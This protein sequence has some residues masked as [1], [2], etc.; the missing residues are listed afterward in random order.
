MEMASF[1]GSIIANQGFMFWSATG[2]VALG[3]TLVLTSGFIHFRRLR[4][5]PGRHD[6]HATVTLPEPIIIPSEIPLKQEMNAESQK[7]VLEPGSRSIELNTQQLRH[8][9]ARLR[10]AADQLEDFRHSSRPVPAESAES[11]LKESAEG[12]DYLFRTGIG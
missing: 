4:S 5:R 1:S 10:T 6:L 12:V 8:L 7:D 9:L 2:A 11:S 3:L